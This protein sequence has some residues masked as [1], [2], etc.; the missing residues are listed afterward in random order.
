TS[1]VHIAGAGSCTITASQAGDNN[2]NA[3]PN[4]P[5]SFTIAKATLNVAA[6]TP[7]STQYSD[8]LAPLTA[9]IT[10]FVNGDTLA[11]AVSGSPAL[12]TTAT[13]NSAPGSYSI[14]V[15]LGSLSAANYT[16]TGFTPATYTITQENA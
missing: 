12:T 14:T 2:Y 8:L 7:T 9:T 16:F 3:S 1:T 15:T 4:V 6:N 11:T 5:Q 13:Q 10:G